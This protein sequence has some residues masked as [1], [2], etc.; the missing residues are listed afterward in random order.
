M[1][2]FGERGLLTTVTISMENKIVLSK[3]YNYSVYYNNDVKCLEALII[4]R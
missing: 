3:K 1:S 2:G 4:I